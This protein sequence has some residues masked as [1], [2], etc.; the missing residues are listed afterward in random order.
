MEKCTAHRSTTMPSMLTMSES[1]SALI[2]LHTTLMLE[3][4]RV[5]CSAEVGRMHSGVCST[6]AAAFVLTASA[7]VAAVRHAT[8]NASCYGMGQ[9]VT[10]QPG[11]RSSRRVT[12]WE[13]TTEVHV[14]KGRVCGRYSTPHHSL[15]DSVGCPHPSSPCC[16]TSH[17]AKDVSSCKA[18][19]RWVKSAFRS[20]EA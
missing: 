17:I 19:A 13:Q 9:A 7:V 8:L 16:Q 20:W 10:S 4:V 11:I 14:M 15:L 1:A 6:A 2:R 12:S 3:Y 18:W 5:V